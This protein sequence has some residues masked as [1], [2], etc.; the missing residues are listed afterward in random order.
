MRNEPCSLLGIAPK[1]YRYAR[2]IF[3]Y[4]LRQGI[5]A[6][7]ALGSRELKSTI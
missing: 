6:S 2:D 3:V 7:I 1:T 4:Y 5:I